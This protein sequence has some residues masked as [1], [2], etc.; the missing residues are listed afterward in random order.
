MGTR[1]IH[2]SIQHKPKQQNLS[3][4]CVTSYNTQSVRK[5]DGL[6]LQPQTSTTQGD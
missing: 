2:N 5:G 6:I 1:K 3:W 4:L